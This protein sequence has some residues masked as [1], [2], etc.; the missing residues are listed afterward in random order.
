MTARL[1]RTLNL[2]LTSAA[3]CIAAVL[4]YRELRP[5]VSVAIDDGPLR[6]TRFIEWPEAM[7]LGRLSG[8]S[9]A[10][11]QVLVFS[12]VECPGCRAFHSL[13]RTVQQAD[14]LSLAVRLIPFPLP[15]HR[16]ATPASRLLECARSEGYFDTMLDVLYSHQDSLGL[17]DWASFAEEA[18]WPAGMRADRCAMSSEPVPYLTDAKAFGERAGVRA[19][20]TVVVNGWRLNRVPT[21]AELFEARDRVRAGRNAFGD[22]TR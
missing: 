19:T 17:K 11:L 7:T 2:L 15:Q 20:P 13:A 12:D 16:F 18:G 10:T 21:Q 6:A 3:V 22:T 9:S 4:L 14:S 8:S 5:G 1:E